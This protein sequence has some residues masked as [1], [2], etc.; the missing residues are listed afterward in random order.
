MLTALV[1]AVSLAA[2]LTVEV[3]DHQVWVRGVT[4]GGTVALYGAGIGLGTVSPFRFEDWRFGEDGDRDG[5][6]RLFPP[7]GHGY[8]TTVSHAVW[9]AVDMTSGAWG[10]AALTL[11]QLGRPPWAPFSLSRSNFSPSPPGATAVTF[12]CGGTP[13]G[14]TWSV[15]S[16][17]PLA[18]LW[19]ATVTDTGGAGIV[20]VP[21]DLAPFPPD[22]S[23]PAFLAVGD[24]LV[25]IHPDASCYTVTTLTPE[26][27][28]RRR[29][30][31]RIRLP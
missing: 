6:V 12:A 26:L 18:R 24:V 21:G 25:A 27:V 5:T 7:T 20:V 14:S 22:A 23:P 30:R 11:V 17:R 31:S 28:V 16:I 15:A 13:S 1:L 19:H 3:A 8:D 2:A 9:V 10:E 29:V 4:P